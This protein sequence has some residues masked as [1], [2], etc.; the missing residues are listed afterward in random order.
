M[1]ASEN[2]MGVMPIRQLIIHMSWPMMLSM[3]VQALYNMVDSYF[4]A[5]YSK[6]AFV[7]LSY[8][9]PAQ[10]IMIAIC[11]GTG[12]GVNALLARRLGEKRVEEAS[13]VALNGYLVYFLTWVVF[14]VLALTMSRPFIGFF[15]DDSVVLDY[16]TQYL[17]IVIGASIGVCLQFA[18]ERILQATGDAIGPMVVQGVGAIINLILDPIFIFGYF[19]VPA[20]GVAGAA[21]ATVLGQIVGMVVGLVMVARNKTLPFRFRGFRPDKATIMDI[22]RIGG[23]A[24]VMQSLATVMNLGM[25]KILSLET[26]KAVYDNALVF[27]LGAYF[28]LQSFVFMPVFGMNNGLTPV[29]SYNYGAKER[30]RITDGIHFA[31]MVS[32]AIMAAGTLLFLALPGPLMSIFNPDPATLVAGIPAMRIASVSFLFAGVSIILTAAF[33]ALGAP[34]Y[35]LIISVMRQLVIVLPVCL[36]FALFNPTLV[37]WCLPAAEIFS[38]VVALLLY[39][40]VHR[41]HIMPLEEAQP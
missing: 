31:M 23:P 7:A 17:S 30:K 21:I 1:E 20:M 32:L 8:A 37:F 25:N 41:E 16:G 28:K 14:L 4:V 26:V 2:K 24:I 12:V 19:G 5:Q 33:Q 35:S 9:Y 40:K 22:Y 15:T 34:R 27:I 3:L 11:V 6:E 13:A 29:L 10:T 18:A 38:C 39:K 36:L